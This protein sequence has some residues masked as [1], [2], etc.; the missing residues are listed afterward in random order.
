MGGKWSAARGRRPAG[1]D[2]RAVFADTLQQARAALTEPGLLER[3][4]QTPLGPAPGAFLVHIRTNEYLAHGWDIADATGQSIDFEP[5][6]AEQALAAWRSRFAETPR[7][8]GGPFGPER[9]APEGASAA[10]KLA[11]FPGREPVGGR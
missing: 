5:E 3:T 6:L 1:E 4:V 7:G 2:F 10:D 8:P 9:V 11:P